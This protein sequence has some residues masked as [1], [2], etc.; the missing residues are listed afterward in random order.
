MDT[1]DHC[2]FLFSTDWFYM[3]NFHVQEISSLSQ[4]DHESIKLIARRHAHSMLSKV[5]NYFELDFSEKRME[6]AYQ[7]FYNDVVSS[8]EKNGKKSLKNLLSLIYE[9]GGKY[10]RESWLLR[11]AYLKLPERKFSNLLANEVIACLQKIIELTKFDEFD[12][13]SMQ[14]E[15]DQN[16]CS[17]FG[18]NETEV[19]DFYSSIVIPVVFIRDAAACVSGLHENDRALLFEELQNAVSAEFGAS[20]AKDKI[21]DIHSQASKY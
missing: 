18:E 16:L 10:S 9:F 5:G 12:S 19:F 15:W 20:I 1:R 21:Q 7:N 8:V 2:I 3:E 13:R 6:M 11:L 4:T 17:F 14:S